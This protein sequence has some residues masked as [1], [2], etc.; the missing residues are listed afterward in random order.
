MFRHA[1]LIVRAATLVSI[2]TIGRADA[3]EHGR[4]QGDRARLGELFGREARPD[5]MQP[6][7]EGTQ[8]HVVPASALLVHNSALPFSLNDGHL[9]A[10]RGL[11]LAVSAGIG[12]RMPVGLVHVSAQLAPTVTWSQN[13]PF[14]IYPYHDTRR[15]PFASP[16]FAPDAS[17]D[18]PMRFG[19]LPLLAI[20]P[21]ESH[22][23][24]AGA[25]VA[26]GISSEEQWWGPGIR[27]A[28]V[29]SNNAGGIPRVFLRTAAPL[30]S[31]IGSFEAIL[32]GGALTESI[33]F[34][35]TSGND[36]R[37][38]SGFLVS[39]RPRWEP[40]LTVGLGRVVY[41]PS[42][43]ASKALTNL[44][45]AF[46]IWEAPHSPGEAGARPPTTDQLLSLFWRWVFPGSGLEA[47]GEWARSEL[48]RSI[49]EYLVA[50]QHSQGYTA[51]LQ[52]ARPVRREG[53]VLRLQA[54]LTYLEQNRA[55]PGRHPTDFYT[56]RAA[57][58]GYTHRGQAIG[59]AIGPGSSSQWL[60]MDY[61]GS[62]RSAGMFAGRIR[63]H[64]D[65]MYRRPDPRPARRDVTAFV[66]GRSSGPIW[67]RNAE[68]EL[69]LARRFNYLFQ[70]EAY[71]G[72]AIDPIDITNLTLAMRFV[73]R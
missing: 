17:A 63:W 23:T 41:R 2:A 28:L 10:G 35:T 43:G 30:E 51:G 69:T 18:L 73:P 36:F 12:G 49:R 44:L 4:A 20:H 57:E 31:R 34:D 33:Y 29:M 21:G 15:S 46:F 72:A 59:A 25:R 66:G 11:N 39:Y 24:I 71:L 37:S 56:G 58:Q 38:I 52:F 13:R 3:Q 68:V 1:I 48:P 40:N 42:S 67:G 61:M 54:E 6:A 45:D 5:S 8:L 55:L 62:Q 16:F 9:W 65:A 47:Y 50:P 7:G 64:T 32:I 14:Q 26:G 19:S 22:V 60:A 70:N 53:D 27:N